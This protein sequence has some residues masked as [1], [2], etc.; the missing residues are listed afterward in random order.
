MSYL[1]NAN[2]SNMPFEFAAIAGTLPLL[3][4]VANGWRVSAISWPL[5]IHAHSVGHPPPALLLSPPLPA[6]ASQGRH[7]AKSTKPS[8]IA[9][10]CK[11]L[12]KW[13]QQLNI[14]C[15]EIQRCSFTMPFPGK[16]L[17]QA[18]P[19]MRPGSCVGKIKWVKTK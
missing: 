17:Q 6:L 1:T 7:S 19:I 15:M 10:E 11:N 9:T 12:S 16:S 14:N 18:G 13:P 2:G 4:C 3:A 8:F 5:A